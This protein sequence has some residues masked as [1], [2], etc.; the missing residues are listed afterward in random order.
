MIKRCIHIFPNFLNQTDIQK[1]R[2]QYD[3]IYKL[4]PPHITLV[5]PFESNIPSKEL[6]EHIEISIA[7]LKPFPIHLQGITGT[8]D[9]YLFLVKK[10]NDSII[11]LHDQLYTGILSS[12]LNREYSYLPHLTIGKLANIIDFQFAL[13][14]TL[15]FTNSFKTIVNEIVVEEIDE[16]GK[17]HIELKAHCDSVHCCI[18]LL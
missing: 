5:F 1:L 18:F 13:N 3:P 12:Y 14:Q 8:Q 7:K 17:S 4:I 11:E 9:F 2:E 6:N 10:G 15:H 16:E